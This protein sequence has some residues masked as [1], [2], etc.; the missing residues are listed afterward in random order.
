M[1]DMT[2]KAMSVAAANHKLGWK[3][4]AARAA[5]VRVRAEKHPAFILIS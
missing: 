4:G 5:L 3:E 1:A 2:H